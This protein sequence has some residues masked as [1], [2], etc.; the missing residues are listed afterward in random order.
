MVRKTNHAI[1]MFAVSLQ[2]RQVVRIILFAH[3]GGLRLPPN[4][5]RFVRPSILAVKQK[6]HIITMFGLYAG[7]NLRFTVSAAS[8][9]PKILRFAVYHLRKARF[10]IMG[11]L[12]LLYQ[13]FDPRPF[14]ERCFGGF[15]AAQERFGCAATGVSQ[16]EFSRD[17]GL[18]SSEGMEPTPC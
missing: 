2:Y 5:I 14:R 1:T 13:V 8:A 4:L 12:F 16:R 11:T 17:Q 15:A 3:G 9:R 6:N 7:Q 18:A 10:S